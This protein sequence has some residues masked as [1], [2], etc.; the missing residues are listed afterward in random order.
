MKKN[1]QRVLV[2]ED[3]DMIRICINEYLLH[4]GF[5]VTQ[6]ENAEK[7]LEMFNVNDFDF[8][9]IDYRM[10]KMNGLE[11]AKEIRKMNSRAVIIMIS[12][13]PNVKYRPLDFIDHFLEKPFKFEEL[14]HLLNQPH[15]SAA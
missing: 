6:A 2:V 13:D 3:D 15:V 10:P 4:M 5:K 9:V 7:G 11:M 8:A 12:G 14:N 1:Q